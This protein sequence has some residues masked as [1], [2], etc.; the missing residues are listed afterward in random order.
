MKKILSLVLAAAMVMSLA[1]CGDKGKTSQSGDDSGSGQGTTAK[2]TL[3]IGHYG[4]TPNFDTHNNLNDNGMRINLSVYDPLVRMDNT[5]YEIKPCIAESWTISENGREYTFAIKSGVKFSDGT[6]MTIDDVIFSME[7]GMEMPMAVPSFARVTGVEKVDDS[8][9]KLILD[10]PYPEFLFAMA[11]PTAGILSKAAFES[12][13]EEAYAQKPV[14]TGPYQVSDWKVGEQVVLK[15]NEYYHMGEV[16]IKNVVYQVIA[17]ANSAVLA[18]ESGD[19]DAYVDVQQSSF[20]RIKENK[21]LVLHTG[22]AFGMNFIQL[23]CSIPPF[24]KLEAR[25]AMAHATDKEAMLY[26]ILDNVGTIVDTFATPGYLGYTDDVTKYPYDLEK[27]KELFAQAG[28]KEGDTLEII[29]Y[30]TTTSKF[31]QVL[32]NSL[33]EIGIIAHINQMERSAFDATAL[34]GS[35]NIIVDGGTFTAPTIDEVLYTLVH[36]SQMEIRNYS[37][38]SNAKVDELLDTAR[39]T[40]DENERDAIYQELLIKL[41]DDVP[42]IPT[43]WN[44]K[45]IA[46]NKDLKGVASNPW[47]FY[48]LYEFSWS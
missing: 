33:R 2:D 43:I 44:T 42:S 32:Q 40:L 5:S 41:S 17:D 9:V 37:K 10:G 22:E 45:N 30:G 25:Q 48:N 24:D 20:G 14:T 18:L 16:P 6:D 27:A 29:L 26:G 15:A 35:A 13:G 23:N 31:A 34:E 21:N 12:M 36:S 19:I 7:R 11:L 1:A 8:H 47:S 4:D 39:I 46:A 3:I 38:Y 28:V